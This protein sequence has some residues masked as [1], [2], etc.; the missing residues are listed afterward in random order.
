MVVHQPVMLDEVISSLNLKPG[1]VVLDATV[2]GGGHAGAILKCVTPGG[3]LIGLDA[4]EYAIKAAEEGL[5]EF[6]GSFKLINENFRDLDRVLSKEGIK[7]LNAVLFDVGV[8]S[9]QLDSAERGFSMKED[10]PLDMRMDRRR[11]ISAFDIINRYKESD[12]SDIIYRYGEER[13]SRKIARRIVQERAKKPIE[14][15]AEL[16]AIVRRSIGPRQKHFRIDPA[17]RTFQAIRIAVNDEL[18]A[19][20]EGLKKAVSWLDVG[21]RIAVIAFHSL[22]DRIVKNLFKGYAGLGVLKIITKKP[23][24]P[25]DEEVAAN[26]RSRSAHLR[27]AERI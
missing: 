23:V 20:E 16:A 10:A 21:S 6:S 24:G 13:F 5:K 8:S 2:G 17:T 22:E 15:T 18:A 3:R 25:S 7:S 14:T 11:G 9:F 4:D 1:H 19:L 12:I 26:P 27:V